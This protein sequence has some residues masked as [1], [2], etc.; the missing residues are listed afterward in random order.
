MSQVKAKQLKLNAAGDIL[1][2]GVNGAGTV[3]PVGS[4][5]QVLRVV[6][7]NLSWVDNLSDRIVSADNASHVVAS[8]DEVSITV[9]ETLVASFATALAADSH[10]SVVADAGKITLEATGSAEN[11][12]LILAAKGDG[13]VV[14]G[15]S[16]SGAIQADDG[17]DL[18][19]LGGAG[20]GNLFLNGGGT[21]KVYYADDATDP[22]KE[23]ATKGDIA[24]AV[25]DVS[26]PVQGRTQF[27]GDET[28]ALPASVL[29]PSVVVSINGLTLLNDKYSV[30]DAT[31]VL[32][33]SN[34]P[35]ELDAMDEVV[36]LYD[37]VA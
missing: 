26:V 33:F 25:G 3:L 36:V 27:T 30:D 23:I 5:S 21:G 28:F 15:S 7:G 20:A 12:D 16:G 10:L 11:V 22:N 31:K 4:N 35:Y 8:S 9:D 2:G 14:I 37:Y 13:D 29:V 24:A 19:L 34:L 6:D 32:T 18:K 17:Y 1:I